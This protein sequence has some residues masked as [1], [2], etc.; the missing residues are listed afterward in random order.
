MA[1]IDTKY[2]LI[3]SQER[4]FANTLATKVVDRPELSAWMIL[5]PI[6]FIH[7]FY[8]HQRFRAAMEITCKEFMF[9]KQ[10]ALD[11]AMEIVQNGTPKAEALA[12]HFPEQEEGYAEE[13]QKIRQEQLKEIELLIDHYTK[14]LK[15]EGN[16]YQLLLKSAYRTRTDY[17]RFLD[18]LQ[19]AEKAVNLAAV[20]AFSQ[21]EG[22]SETISKME[23]TT[24]FL[25]EEELKA[26]F[27]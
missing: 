26:V 21:T 2:H 1:S 19:R 11:A 22:F 16:D 13:A 20:H 12:A 17:A 25:R 7:Y 18:Q 9:T 8:Q 27:S 3:I 15:A 23:T 6:I 5:I 24:I 10:T 4:R 14:L